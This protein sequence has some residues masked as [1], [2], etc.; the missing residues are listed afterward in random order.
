MYEASFGLRTR[1]FPPL[2]CDSQYFPATAIEAARQ[3]LIRCVQRGEGPAMVIG[4]SG[5]GKTLLC[6]LL[7]AHFR[8]T[9]RVAVLSRGWLSTR[10]AL[11]QAILYELGENYRG[12][13]EGEL[14]LALVEYATAGDA[15]PNGLLLVVDE[16][17]TLPLR[18]LD[19]IRM[20]TNLAADGQPR[21]RLVL[22]GGAA[23]EERFAAPKLDSFSQRIVARCYLEALNR[24]ETQLYVHSLVNSAGGRGEALF[25]RDACE[26]V[27][28]AS[29][30]VPRIINQVCDHALFLAASGGHRQVDAGCVE[31]AWADLQQLPTPWNADAEAAKPAADIIE[32]G[33]LDEE[34]VAEEA[35][36]EAAETLPLLRITPDSDESPA[37]P[38]LQIEQIEDA[39]AQLQSDCDPAETG[40]P[41]VELFFS[42]SADPFAEPF[43]EEEVIVERYVVP[44]SPGPAA[45]P[46]S[47]TPAAISTVEIC[48]PAMQSSV[49]APSHEAAEAVSASSVKVAPP[50]PA[51]AAATTKAVSGTPPAKD[52][53][54]LFARLR[55]G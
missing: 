22:A 55:G 2:P 30:G 16:A 53:R 14:R 13:D 34:D 11:L 49:A 32:F 43:Q 12:M 31:E 18:L 33:G 8:S 25:S 1:P 44:S 29:D 9:L 45:L 54:R 4:P 41:E 50:S 19:E 26:A 20:L 21:V 24:S 5:T 48:E 47:W 46:A 39:V 28:R 3:T 37:E 7:A 51:R 17:H 38:M 27:H 10:R 23:L 36:S 6:Q 52:F 42:Q 35:P 15:C 40:A